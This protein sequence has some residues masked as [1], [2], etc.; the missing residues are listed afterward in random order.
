MP[1]RFNPREHL[2]LGRYALRWLLVATPVSVAI[3]IACAIFLYALDVATNTRE[4]HPA[5]LYFL[6]LGGV[7]IASLYHYLGRSA[8]GGNNLLIDEVHEPSAGVP[9]RMAPLILL[10]T[11]LTHLFGGS[12]GREGTAIQ[13]GGSIASSLARPFKLAVQT[14]RTLLMVGMAAGFGAV[15]GTPL[16]GAVFAMEVLAVGRITY[17]ALL[18]CLIAA[19]IADYT[20][21]AALHLVHVSHTDY[22]FHLTMPHLDAA[23]LAKIAVAAVA[24]GLVANLFAEVTHGLGRVSKKLIPHPLLRPVV[25]GILVIGIVYLLGTRDYIGLGVHPSPGGHVS[26]TTA[27]TPAGATSMSWFWKLLLTAVTLSMGFKGGEVTPLFFIGATLGNVCAKVLHVP[28]DVFPLFPAAGFVAVF[29]GATNTPLACTLMGIELFGGDQSI[30]LAVAC[31]VAY[32]FSGHTG[33]YSSQR[34]A[35][36]KHPDLPLH[37]SRR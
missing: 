35:T 37:A 20:C 11:V 34:F 23:T 1:F 5:L 2:A 17:E 15:F 25:G 22:H 19:V 13:M 21:G 9:A 18:P 24:F 30:Y 16:A 8:E 36:P 4:A 26:I 32:F 7:L 10:T 14:A 28:A 6:P 29:A 33:I 12:A 27:F 3:G 31:F